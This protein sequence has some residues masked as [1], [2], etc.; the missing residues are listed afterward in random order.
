MSN[1]EN[2]Q[3]TLQE[4]GESTENK[5]IYNDVQPKSLGTVNMTN[6]ATGDV[7]EAKRVNDKFG[8]ISLK[9]ED[10]PSMGKFYPIN[11]SISIRAARVEEIKDFSIIDDTNIIDMDE[12]LSALLLNC[13]IFSKPNQKLSY[14]DLLEEDKLYIILSI[15]ELTFKNGESKML[16]KVS[17]KK[18]NT[19]NEIELRTDFLQ[20]FNLDETIEK[21]YSD[22][23]RCYIV[24]TKTYGDIPLFPPK[25]GVMKVIQD[26]IVKS[27]QEGHKWDKSFMQLLPYLI[28]DWRNFDEKQIRDYNIDFVGWDTKKYSIILKMAQ[29]I[30]VGLQENM[31]AP[32]KTCNHGL[33]TPIT[34]FLSSLKD[35]FIISDFSDELL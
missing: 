21:Y 31:K 35:L 13:V 33:E 26:Y 15:R 9:M 16:S 30:K 34:F 11:S 25:I 1:K 27:S 3:K 10:L 4:I 7:E 29:K 8:F 12:K 5:D 17:C 20:K 19:E 14:K 22:E 24:Q 18:C 32:C 2:Y 23:Y 28:G 6:F